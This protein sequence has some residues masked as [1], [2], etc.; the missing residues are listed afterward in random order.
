MFVIFLKF[1]ANRE[2]AGEFMDGHNAWLK[3]GFDDGVFLLAGSLQPGLG[4]AVIARDASREAIEVR[5]E[6]DPFVDQGVVDAEILEFAPGMADER[7]QFL[8]G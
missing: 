2:R 1:S 7:L 8:V 4:G 5:V 3:Q 6:A